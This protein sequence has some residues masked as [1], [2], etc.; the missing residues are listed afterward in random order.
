MLSLPGDVGGLEVLDG[1]RPL[2]FATAGPTLAPD[3]SLLAEAVRLLDGAEPVTI[4]A[5]RGAI[6]ARSRCCNWPAASRRRWS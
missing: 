4:L 2:R 1:D 3:R 5:G 6:A